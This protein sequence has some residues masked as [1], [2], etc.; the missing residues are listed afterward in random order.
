MKCMCHPRYNELKYRPL[1]TRNKNSESISCVWP[2]GRNDLANNGPLA[3]R[4]RSSNVWPT[5]WKTGYSDVPWST[6]GG[7]SSFSLG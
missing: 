4:A 3:Q 2:T 7:G 6:S 1:G 5:G